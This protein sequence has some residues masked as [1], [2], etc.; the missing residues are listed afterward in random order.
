MEWLPLFTLLIFFFLPFSYLASEHLTCLDRIHIDLHI[1]VEYDGWT[2]FASSLTETTLD[3]E[4]LR[5]GVEFPVS[6]E[7]RHDKARKSL[8]TGSTSTDFYSFCLHTL[9]I[10]K[11][12]Q[13]AKKSPTAWMRDFYCSTGALTSDFKF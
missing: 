12:T 7:A 11:L 6:L 3:H 5:I 8:T 1:V 9:S 4:L 13:K 10:E 2:F